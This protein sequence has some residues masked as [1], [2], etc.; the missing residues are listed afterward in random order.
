MSQ[1]SLFISDLHLDATRP[2]IVDLFFDFLDKTASQASEL[3]ILGDL[4]EVWIGDDDENEFNQSIINKLRETA[5]KGINL[6]IM[7]GNRDFL[8]GTVFEKASGCKRLDDPTCINLFNNSILLMHGDS[9]CTDDLKYQA[10]R[11]Y[12]RSDAMRVELM[13]KTLDERREIAKQAR[14]YSLEATKNNPDSIMDVNEA[15]VTTEFKKHHVST[16]IHG[17]THRMKQHSVVIDGENC[18]RIV[19]GDWHENGNYL[20]VSSKGYQ[21]KIIEP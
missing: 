17:H 12:V 14:H 3:Y 7:R 10:I 20:E 21:M 1:P 5:D 8:I 4:F 6:Y 9:L 18:Q 15:A 16:M 2:I 11:E 13:S 19:L